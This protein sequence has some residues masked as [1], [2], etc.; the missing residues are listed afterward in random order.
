MT[1]ATRSERMA[2]RI[3]DELRDGELVFVGVGTAGRAFTLAVGIPLVAARLAQVTSAPA[4][5]IY[6]GNLLNPDLADFPSELTQ[7]AITRWRGA[8]APAD[9]G[10]K[11]DMLARGEFDVSFE[12]APQIDRH[13][14]LNI[15]EIRT[16]ERAVRL[17]GTL[18][19][20]EHYAY[21]RR[22]IVVTD[23]ASRTFVEKVDFIT[24]FGFGDGEGRRA[25]LGYTTPG[26]HLIVTDMC[27]FDFFDEQM[28][29]IEV[30]PGVGVDDVLERMSFVPL[31][32]GPRVT[33]E[34][35]DEDLRLI[36]DEIDAHGVMLAH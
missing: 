10:Y 24:S 23:L 30:Y 13:G 31:I 9:V 26:P 1:G 11:V 4:L 14:N 6:W 21:V 36:R 18:A 27:V 2:V 12:S 8:Y 15:T 25:D 34:P 17:V 28:R 5:D 16:G 35:T 3:S 19:Q 22:P 32:D 20:P 29:L 7:D 33:R